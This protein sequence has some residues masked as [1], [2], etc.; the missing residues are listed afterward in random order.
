METT[1]RPGEVAECHV[2]NGFS[3]LIN[4]SKVLMAGNPSA[5]KGL[6]N[7]QQLPPFDIAAQSPRGYKGRPFNPACMGFRRDRYN[8]S[9]AVAAPELVPTVIPIKQFVEI[10]ERMDHPTRPTVVLQAFQIPGEKV[11]GRG[12]ILARL[13]PA[14]SAINVVHGNTGVMIGKLEDIKLIDS[15]QLDRAVLTYYYIACKLQLGSLDRLDKLFS[16][17]TGLSYYQ[18]PLD[19]GLQ[20]DTESPDS[21]FE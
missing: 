11:E 18:I 2:Q 20:S 10:V 17:Y 6:S 5:I 8:V 9:I 14:N 1:I 3:C 7:L 12:E 4:A 21:L 16:A 13:L 19:D 15:F